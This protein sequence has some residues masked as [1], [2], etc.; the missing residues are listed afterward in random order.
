MAKEKKS[1]APPDQAERNLITSD[2]DK[3]MLVEAAA[4][5]GKTT[6][7]IA[8]MVALLAAGK[9]RTDTL[10]AVT[11]T[12]KSTAE[13]RAR[14]QIDL[15]KAA[16]A[17]KGEALCPPGC[18]G[19]HRGAV[20]HRHDPLVLCPFAQGT[21]GRGGRR[22]GI[23]GTGRS[24]RRPTPAAGMGRVYRQ[25]ACHGCPDPGG[26]GGVGDRN[27]RDRADLLQVLRLSRRD[28]V[29]RGKCAAT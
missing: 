4:G 8:R 19:C 17:A 24:G 28:R 5:T 26:T 6:A 14:F 11:F 13:L 25:A 10:A 21:P 16:R 20:F 27:P 22:C 18:G 15:E 3:T 7:M 1:P 29:A 12:R 9:C 2:L 23:P